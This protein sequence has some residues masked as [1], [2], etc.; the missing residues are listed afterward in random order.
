MH[1]DLL[2][3]GLI[4]GLANICSRFLP[5]WWLQRRRYHLKTSGFKF[6]W[7]PLAMGSIGISAIC[8]MLM[9]ASITPILAAPDKII[10]SLCGLSMMMLSYLACKK[11]LLCTFAAAL[12]YGLVYCHLPMLISTA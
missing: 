10:A 5:L 6:K 7:L 1:L 4:L 9:V 11:L 8:A 3:L 12:G 2:L